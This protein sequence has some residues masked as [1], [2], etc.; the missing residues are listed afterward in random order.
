[1]MALTQCLR[2]QGIEVYDPVVDADGNVGKPEFAEGVDPKREE[3]G[4]AWEACSEHLEG[5]TF[6]KERADLS[7][8]VERLDQF[9]ALAICLRDKG[10]NVD[11]PTAETIDQWMGDFKQVFDWR[12]PAAMA[13]YEDCSGDA[14]MGGGKK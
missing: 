4:A 5:L 3:I 12:D 2:D 10:Y 13:D 11:E 14:G 9:L 6:G 1:M 8:Q 7:D